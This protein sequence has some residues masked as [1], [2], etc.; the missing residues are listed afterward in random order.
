VIECE[1]TESVVTEQDTAPFEAVPEQIVI[2][3][4]MKDTA[5]V[6]LVGSVAFNVTLSVYAD[7][8]GVDT[9]AT[10][11]APFW[12]GVPLLTT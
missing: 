2:V 11:V 3:P 10:A 4:S 9:P 1:P 7:G 8:F 12:P 6:A 5:P